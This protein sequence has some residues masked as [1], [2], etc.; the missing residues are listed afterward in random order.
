M[1]QVATVKS[2]LQWAESE[3]MET[4]PTP[5]L[6][7]QVILCHLLQLNSLGLFMAHSDPVSA[8]TLTQ[9]EQLIE[10]RKNGKPVAYL[11]G[12]KEFMGLDFKVSESVLIP[13]PDTEVLVEAVLNTVL[14]PSDSVPSIDSVPFVLDLCTGS[15]AI[16]ISI[17]HF[18]PTW[19]GMG[20]DLSKEAL[21]VAHSNRTLHDQ[22][23]RLALVEWDVCAESLVEGLEGQVDVL[24]SNPPYIPKH[25]METLPTS[26]IAYEPTMALYGGVDGLDFYRKIADDGVKYLRHH[27][28]LFFEVGHDQGEAVCTILEARGYEN[29]RTYEDLQGFHRVVA[30]EWNRA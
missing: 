18:K 8:E 4:S 15:G 12:I 16:A 30:G 9:F 1:L 3:L 23:H 21:T 26:V 6:D 5:L 11:T 2:C 22:D 10:E 7:G 14:Q 28:Q 29:I 19:L 25:E 13:R 27:G 24:V 20:V 17:L